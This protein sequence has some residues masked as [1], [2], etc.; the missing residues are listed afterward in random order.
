VG[1]STLRGRAGPIQSSNR[2]LTNAGSSLSGL[3]GSAATRR[4]AQIRRRA[5][6]GRCKGTAPREWGRQ[7]Q[8]EPVLDGRVVFG[9]RGESPVRAPQPRCFLAHLSVFSSGWAAAAPAWTELIPAVANRRL[10]FF[11][12]AACSEAFRPYAPCL[13]GAQPAPVMVGVGFRPAGDRAALRFG[14]SRM[15]TLST[16]Q[17]EAVACWPARSRCST[18]VNLC[19]KRKKI[20]WSRGSTD[21]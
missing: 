19:G 14:P 11:I 5:G 20:A 15:G 18:A 2:G 6:M 21:S 4:E 9:P 1:H 8:Q 12:A 7:G 16:P 17:F 13:S 10:A 3:R